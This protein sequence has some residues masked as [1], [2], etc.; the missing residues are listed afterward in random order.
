MKKIFILI[1]LSCLLHPFIYNIDA[2]IYLDNASF[3]GDPADATIPVG[4]HECA[5]L[6][7]PDIL[8][9]VWGVYSEPA[10]GD[11]F[12]GL[13]T[14][15]DGSFESIG[16]RL[17]KPLEKGECYKFELDLAHSDTYSGFG[18]PIKLRVWGGTSRCALNQLVFETDFIKHTEWKT[19]SI[20]FFSKITIN[21][22]ILEA[23]FQEEP[24]PRKGN[25][26]IDNISKI[27]KC[28]RA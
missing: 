20:L 22:L 11:T 13:I 16:Q 14:R 19:Y 2:Q 25:V 17:K 23:H 24:K 1:I 28:N 26:L 9:G 27:K 12:V 4:W 8:P 5:P 7:T 6:T 15:S 21:Y 18:K 10:E 3:E